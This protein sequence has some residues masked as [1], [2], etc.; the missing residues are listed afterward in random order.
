MDMKNLVLALHGLVHS[1]VMWRGVPGVGGVKD[2]LL[3]IK[4]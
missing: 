4:L 1:L 3:N 2:D